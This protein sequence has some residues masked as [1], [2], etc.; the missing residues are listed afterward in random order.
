M[1]TVLVVLACIMLNAALAALEVAFISASKA[2]IRAHAAPEDARVQRFLRL[3]ETPERTLAAIQVGIILVGVVSGAVGGAG[4]QEFFSPFLKH[5]LDLSAGAAKIL[6]IAVVA[7]PLMFATV[8]VGELVPKAL[9]IRHPERVALV[10]ARWLHL[11]EQV[12]LPVV[13]L[14]AWMTK[15]LVVRIPGG[16]FARMAPAPA[17]AKG[18]MHPRYALDLLDLAHRRVSDAMVPWSR[19]AKADASMSPPSVADLALASGHTRLPVIRDGVVVGLLHTK[20]LLTFLAAGEH[21][22]PTLVRPAVTV[23]PGEPLLRVLRLLQQR[24][25][26]LAVVTAPDGA[27]VGIVSLE[28]ILEEVLGDLY[29]EDDDRAVERLLAARGKLKG[30]IIRSAR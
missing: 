25:S 16:A 15:A 21:D 9:A 8:V 14:L 19:T 1:F 28:D 22:W 2:D 11:L 6:A 13:G 27:T 12:F 4:A 3:R 17:D 20:E 26:H 18:R 30:T 23:G 29:D 7:V 10:G 5:C 24:R